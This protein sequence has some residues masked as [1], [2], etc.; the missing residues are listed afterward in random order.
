MNT[1][2]DILRATH[3]GFGAVGLLVFWI[4]VFAKKGGRIHKRAGTIF[5]FCVYVVGTSACIS[6]AWAI[7]HPYSWGRMPANVTPE[8]AASTARQIRGI[9]LFLGSLGLTTL[10][11]VRSGILAIRYRRDPK[12]LSGPGIVALSTACLLAGIA[13]I[14]NGILTKMYLFA[15]VGLI[16][17]LGG[18][19][20]LAVARKPP[21]ERM[22]WWYE[23][24]SNML[25]AGIAFYTAF[26]VFGAGRVFGI[27]FEPPLSFLPWLGPTLV[28]IPVITIWTNKYKRKFA[29]G[30]ESPV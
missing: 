21:T 28:G 13:A 3:I 6:A 8:E 18:W 2:H 29:R 12:A 14:V 11:A 5:K 25:G 9:G 27:S 4:P 24:M 1:F 10:V 20:A 7:L 17:V 22:G 19:S 16:P 23:H 15:G 26:L 30:A